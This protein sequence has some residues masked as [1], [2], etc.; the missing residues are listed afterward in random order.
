M[1]SHAYIGVDIEILWDVAQN[2]VPEL[3]EQVRGMPNPQC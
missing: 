2:K 3:H 1:L